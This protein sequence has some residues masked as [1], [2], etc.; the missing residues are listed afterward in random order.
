MVSGAP[1]CSQNFNVADTGVPHFGQVLC[2]GI[3][4]PHTSQNLFPAG[5]GALH[6]GQGVLGSF[7]LSGMGITGL[8]YPVPVFKSPDNTD[9]LYEHTVRSDLRIVFLKSGWIYKK[10]EPKSA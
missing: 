9:A 7:R 2:T 10:Q 3:V 5:T 8:M 1:H 4:A 6:R